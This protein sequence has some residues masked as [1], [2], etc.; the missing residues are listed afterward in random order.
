MV[1]VERLSI[2]VCLEQR[3]LQCFDQGNFVDVGAGVM[4][5]NTRLHIAVCIDM[6]V[7]S[8]SCDTASDE[9]TVVLE[10]HNKDL[11]VALIGTDLTQSVIDIFSLLN[12]RHQLRCCIHTNRHKVEIPAVAAAMF[13][14]QI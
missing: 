12:R 11:F 13:D 4:D 9:L 5:E 6:A 10:I 14:Q 8:S 2:A 7:V 3:L 1:A